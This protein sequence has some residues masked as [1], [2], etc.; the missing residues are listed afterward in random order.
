MLVHRLACTLALALAHALA[1][2]H[3]LDPPQL[4]FAQQPD[5][6]PPAHADW[7][8]RPLPWGDLNVL[9]T[10][11]SASALT[12]NGRTEGPGADPRPPL[13]LAAAHGWLLGHLRN[14]PSF[15]G[16][17]GG[18]PSL[19][20]PPRSPY[21]AL[22]SL[23]IHSAA[24]APFC[25]E[26]P[27]RACRLLL[28]RAADEGRGPAQVR[29]ALAFPASPCSP[30][31]RLRAL[32]SKRG[33]PLARRLRRPGRRQRSRRCRA[34]AKSQGTDR[35]RLLH[36]DALRRRHDRAFLA[37]PSAHFRPAETTGDW[38]DAQGNHELYK[39]PVAS[40]VS[41]TLSR[42]LGDRWVVSNVNLTVPG[43]GAGE[44]MMGNRVRT[45]RTEMGREVTAIA[46]LFDFKGGSLR[47]VHSACFPFC[48]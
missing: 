17:W 41:E 31:T 12:D 24:R 6:A 37:S 19:S 45:F 43:A 20:L 40:Y 2:A 9:A 22:S 4:T 38:H 11:D 32:R 42:E 15:S 14:E 47:S 18:E 29:R 39:Y 30:L 34:R 28:V 23:T 26:I 33:R 27:R 36:Q 8:Y 44:K 21:N 1:H 7:P 3:P 10:T 25:S 35:A 16:D 48:G 13:A 5:A 46:P